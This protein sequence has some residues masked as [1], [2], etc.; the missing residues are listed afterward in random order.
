MLARG[1]VR[2]QFFLHDPNRLAVDGFITGVGGDPGDGRCPALLQGVFVE[3]LRVDAATL[4]RQRNRL[5]SSL[6]A[7][8]LQAKP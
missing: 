5:V 4:S 7:E 2:E 3:V 6:I 8:G 1:L